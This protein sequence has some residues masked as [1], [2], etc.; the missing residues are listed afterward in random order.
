[1]VLERKAAEHLAQIRRGP[2]S[3]TLKGIRKLFEISNVWDTEWLLAL[4]VCQ[5][6]KAFAWDSKKFEQPSIWD[7]NIQ[8]YAKPNGDSKMTV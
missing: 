3:R 4:A 2:N 1:M 6:T 5:G 7:T 8:L